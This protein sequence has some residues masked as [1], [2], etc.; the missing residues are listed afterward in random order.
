MVEK[1]LKNPTLFNV[2]PF[3][4][5]YFKSELNPLVYVKGKR[6]FITE[7]EKLNNFR[8]VMSMSDE[9]VVIPGENIEQCTVTEREQALFHF[10]L[11]LVMAWLI[12]PPH[13]KTLKQQW[14]W[15]VDHL[16]QCLTWDPVLSRLSGILFWKGYFLYQLE[17]YSEAIDS[18][19]QCLK[20][21]E[22]FKIKDSHQEKYRYMY[23][24][25]TLFRFNF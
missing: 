8:N 9:H 7:L 13:V 11:H 24:A 19:Q 10:N 2:L 15:M 25:G 23:D 3:P 18:F 12:H 17:R 22:P 14:E 6:G 1:Q 21:D 5:L 4:N 16:G 20:E